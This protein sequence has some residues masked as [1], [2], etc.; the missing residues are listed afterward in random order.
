MGSVS[1]EQ[2]CL[3]SRAGGVGLKSVGEL[4]SVVV[5]IP[6]LSKS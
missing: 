4:V 6:G 3:R 1:N 2:R 5:R